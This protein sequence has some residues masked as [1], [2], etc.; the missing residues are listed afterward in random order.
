MITV[1]ER[2]D[3]ITNPPLDA[4]MIHNRSSVD[5]SEVSV[6]VDGTNVATLGGDSVSV[7]VFNINR[8]AWTQ[9]LVIKVLIFY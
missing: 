5:E 2:H 1:S 8:Y 3:R 6:E 9:D 7:S 4:S